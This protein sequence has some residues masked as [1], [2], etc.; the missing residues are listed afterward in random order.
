M[1]FSY[2]V[3]TMVFVENQ[4]Y[5]EKHILKLMQRGDKDAIAAFAQKNGLT[6]EQYTAL[7]FGPRAALAPQLEMYLK[8]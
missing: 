6:Q 5:D 2:P 8:K 4:F 7:L 1:S 3:W